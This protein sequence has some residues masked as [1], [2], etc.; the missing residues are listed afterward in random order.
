MRFIALL[1]F[2][3]GIALGQ[4]DRQFARD[5]IRD[6][7]Q[8]SFSGRGYVKNGSNKA[9]KYI[10]TYFKE[11]QLLSF[12]PN[13]YYQPFSISVNTFSKKMELSIND[14]LLKPGIHYLIRPE[15]TSGKGNLEIVKKDSVS[16]TSNSKNLNNKLVVIKKVKKLTWGVSTSQENY[17]GFDVLSDSLKEEINNISFKVDQQFFTDYELKNVC[18]Y[19]KGKTKSD[20]FLV[21]TA[22]YD[23]LGNMGKKTFFPGANDNASGVSML[24]SLID[25]Y[26]KNP[27]NYSVAF[28]CFAAEEAGLLGSKYYIEHPLFPISQIKFLINLDLLGTGDEG[29]TVVNATEYKTAFESLKSINEKQQLL[30]TIKP[31]GKAA[32]SDHYWFTEKGVPSFFIYTLGG[33]KAYH[34]IYDVEKTLPL[35]KFPEVKKLLIEFANW[36]M[37]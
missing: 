2:F 30:P 6:L 13:S 36:Q 31:R 19:I 15:S 22:H 10:S 4:D 28:I 8:K 37:N 3:S 26:K 7:T 20:S 34:D 9:A 18:A 11:K 16:Y 27:P 14:K 12:T 33:I 1:L 35:T 23:H 5:V 17:I 25:Y 32:N 21:F 29:I 24:F